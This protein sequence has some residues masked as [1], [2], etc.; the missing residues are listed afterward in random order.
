MCS[1]FILCMYFPDVEVA[2]PSVGPAVFC[3]VGLTLGLLGVAMGTFFII[4]GNNRQLT[5]NQT[6]FKKLLIYCL[7]I[8]VCLR[9]C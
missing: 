8:S 5:W 1:S 7:F 4:K 3:G 6:F 2:M 9:H